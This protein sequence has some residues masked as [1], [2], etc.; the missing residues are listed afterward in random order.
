M[1]WSGVDSALLRHLPS[2]PPYISSRDDSPA[3]D[4]NSGPIV[5]TC[6]TFEKNYFSVRRSCVRC[7]SLRLGEGGSSGGREDEFLAYRI[8]YLIYTRNRTDMNNM[9]ADLTTA[10][11]K[12]TYVSL[13][14]RVRAALASGNYHRFFQLYRQYQD[15]NMVPYLMDMF[16]DRERLGAM[17]VICKSYKPDVSSKFLTKELAFACSETELFDEDIECECLTFVTNHGG[18]ALIQEKDGNIRVLTGKAGNVFEM[19]KQAVFGKVDIKGQ[20]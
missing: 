9:L 4:A 15:R 1:L 5:G 2:L 11:K 7:I 20:I 18:D 12:G 14:L 6:Q 19:A 16:I 17:A 13:A 3:V 10:D 8:L